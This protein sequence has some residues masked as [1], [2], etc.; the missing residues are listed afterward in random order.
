MFNSNCS[1]EKV[2]GMGFYAKSAK[3]IFFWS[4]GAG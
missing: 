2:W 3:A 4:E 1:V